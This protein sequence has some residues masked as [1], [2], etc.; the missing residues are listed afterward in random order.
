MTDAHRAL[1]SLI[2]QNTPHLLRTYLR[3]LA[4]G[5][6]LVGSVAAGG[7]ASSH[8]PPSSELD[9]IACSSDRWDAAAGLAPAST[10]DFIGVYQADPMVGQVYSI[11]STGTACEGAGDR[12]ACESSLSALLDEAMFG[13][14]FV[15]TTDADEIRVHGTDQELLDLLGPVDAPADAVLRAWHAGYSV[16]CGDVER[17]A[18]REVAGGYEVVAVRTSGG[19]GTPLVTT[20]YLLMVSTEGA[21]T[22]LAEE[23]VERIDDAG[24]A[25]RRPDGLLPAEGRVHGDAVGHWLASI[26]RLEASAVVAFES[27]A[28]ELVHHGAPADLVT[29][30]RDAAA[31]E[32]RHAALMQEQ[33]ARFGASPFACEV[34]PRPVRSLF[35]IA[36]ENAVEGCLRETYGALVAHHQALAARDRPLAAVM[37]TIAEDESRHA[38]LSWAIASW[39][40]PRLT[41][42]ERH[43]LRFAQLAALAEL[44][45]EM[46]RAPD[47]RVMDLAGLPRPEIAL[48]L[49]EE[50]TRTLL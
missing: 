5:S 42:A 25:G 47:T 36:L 21:I 1:R 12:A 13:A 44:R 22:V 38:E 28:D 27:L 10:P 24:C 2:R 39:I 35:S 26:G 23:E 11:G 30:A 8:F 48:G 7:C 15:V 9:E 33:A 50:L 40:E 18:V 31:D 34:E 49:L 45:A 4:A 17:S 46:Q 19:C 20:R 14:R 16:R 43:Q 3:R 41:D 32:V 6:V 29:R 37:A